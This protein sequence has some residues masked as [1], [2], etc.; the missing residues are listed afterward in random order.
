MLLQKN[1][2][3]Y[4]AIVSFVFVCFAVMEFVNHRFWMSDFRVYYEAASAYFN[5]SPVYNVCFTLG[6]GYYK[7]SPFALFLFSPF[8]VFP[9]AI[10]KFIYFAFLCVVILFTVA[11]SCKII[12][13]KLFG[14]TGNE[15]GSALLFIITLA[16]VQHI[17]FELHLGNVNIVLLL[18]SLVSLS[19]FLNRKNIPA[20]IL[21]AVAVL[22]KP[23]FLILIPLFLLRKKFRFVLSFFSALIA[24]L[25]IPALYTGFA[26][27][28][29][30]LSQ[31]K[32][33]IL[34]HVNSPV[35]AQDTLYSWIYRA[36]GSTVPEQWQ[37]Y[38]IMLILFAVACFF[39][40][41]CVKHI[42]KESASGNDIKLYE[43]NFVFEFILLVALIPNLTVTDSEH[44]LFSLPLIAWLIN[45]I[46][47]RK[48]R[49]T[50]TIIIVAAILLYDMNLRDLI[51]KSL[52][53]WMTET[54]ILGLGNLMMIGVGIY[55]FAK[56]QRK[57]L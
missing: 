26:T 3:L 6:S 40:I 56:D 13:A 51:G 4:F 18:L 42:C 2:R 33:A 20:G 9:F 57:S 34:S 38:F 48:P 36:I 32:D 25:L 47:I 31:W 16:F 11:Y 41:L 23:H 44:F 19:L 28:F 53:R 24:G 27:N 22:I 30:L 5:D 12:R 7:Y 21:L 35:T 14:I 52:S 15:A 43:K 45:Y 54:G 1:N 29:V 10:A 17:Y 37:K 39:L 50:L 46:F 55:L 49:I 8:V